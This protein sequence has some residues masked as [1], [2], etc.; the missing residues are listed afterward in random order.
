MLLSNRKTTP[1]LALAL[2]TGLSLNLWDYGL[3][4]K[5]QNSGITRGEYDAAVWFRHNSQP[6]DR[7]IADYYR[8]QMIG[9]VAG[10][11]ALLGGVFPLR[12]VDHPYI[13]APGRV[14]NDLFILYNT[15]NPL[16][17]RNIAKRYNATHVFY[18]DNMRGYGNLLSYYKTASDYGVDVELE[19]FEDEG[20]FEVVHEG[21]T[22][23]GVVRIYRVK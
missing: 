16:I 8:A 14:Q 9:G 20:Y 11:K 6:S 1:I 4:G 15:S 7:I 18:S 22:P 12:N 17:A 21:D 3:P 23:Y 5:F 10:G 2:L 19:K 13:R